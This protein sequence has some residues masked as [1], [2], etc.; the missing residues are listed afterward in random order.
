[1]VAAVD[2][3]HDVIERT[4]DEFDRFVSLVAVGRDHDI[5]HRHADLGLFLPRQREHSDRPSDQRGEQ[6]QRH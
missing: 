1:M 5:D 2:A 6:K 4:R 3:L